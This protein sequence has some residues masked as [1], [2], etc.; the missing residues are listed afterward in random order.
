MIRILDVSGGQV[1]DVVAFKLDDSTERLNNGYTQLMS[2]TLRLREG[3]T[4]YSNRCTPMFAILHDR[5]GQNHMSGAQCSEPL[6]RLRYGTA[7]TPNCRDNLVRALEPWGITDDQ[8][9]GSFSAF[10]N[11]DIEPDGTMSIR[12]PSSEAG[13]F[14]DLEARMD[15]LV[16]VS[17]CPQDQNPCNA[18]NPTAIDVRI[19][20]T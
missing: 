9:P 1:A 10:M 5:V 15:L 17:A 19:G 11:V 6:N 18:W 4:L 2:G 3:N 12:Q 8:L 7:N 14:I 13:D 16:A 20:P